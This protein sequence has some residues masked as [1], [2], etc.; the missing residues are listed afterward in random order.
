MVMIMVVMM[1]MTIAMAT[2]TM[3]MRR[4][5]RRRKRKAVTCGA[6]R[7]YLVRSNHGAHLGRLRAVWGSCGAVMGSPWGPLEPL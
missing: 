1:M 6:F 7:F 3:T 4:R 5:R 2:T